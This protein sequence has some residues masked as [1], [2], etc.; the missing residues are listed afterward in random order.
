M[1]TATVPF[2][3]L[4]ANKTGATLTEQMA[5]FDPGLTTQLSPVI[6]FT[7]APYVGVALTLACP[8]GT[9]TVG[10]PYSSK[11]TASGGVPPYAFIDQS[12]LPAGL[13]LDHVTGAITGTPQNAG[14]LTSTI[15]VGD[16]LLGLYPDN[17][18]HADRATADCAI[19]IDGADDCSKFSLDGPADV[20]GLSEYTY[21]IN[22]GTALAVGVTLISWRVD[23]LSTASVNEPANMFSA[24]V[25]FQNTHADLVTITAAFLYGAAA[26]CEVKKEVALVKVDIGKAYFE[27]L[28]RPSGRPD[29]QDIFLVKAPTDHSAPNW[30]TT[31]DPDAACWTPRGANAGCWKEFTS[32]TTPKGREPAVFVKSAGARKPNGQ[33]FG[34][35]FVAESDVTL[36]S[37]VEKPEALQKIQVGFI[38]KGYDTGLAFYQGGLTRAVAIP[39]LDTV[40]WLTSPKGP[41]PDDEWPWYDNDQASKTGT[42]TGLWRDTLQMSDSPSDTIPKKYNP[43][44]DLD[45]NSNK[46]LLPHDSRHRASFDLY[47]AAR[48]LDTDL[49]ADKHY[50]KEAHDVWE[51]DL[52]WPVV[53]N[54]STVR[55]FN[56]DWDKPSAPSE[57]NVHV[58]PAR[59]NGD[60][61]FLRWKCGSPSCNP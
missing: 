10:V 28:G 34:E 16:S 52:I 21:K 5:I 43:T 57:V 41:A 53:E 24:V 58:V 46:E 38:Q 20:P 31:F 8:A 27:T 40:D 22:P 60:T 33:S 50:F 59:I 42:G 29:F 39:T 30:V 47:I 18:V 9:A 44:D 32:N 25:K 7:Q 1:G 13:K 51:A 36:T 19:L 37:P 56:D 26:H 35:A 15:V 14:T 54:V 2:T 23:K 3:S 12:A 48:T 4:E 49:G 17:S 6:V 61:P 11:V 55:I 45:L